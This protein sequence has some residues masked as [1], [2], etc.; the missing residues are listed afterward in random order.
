L[1]IESPVYDSIFSF[2]LPTAIPLL[3]FR[4]DIRKIINE[5]GHTLI[6]FVLGVIGVLL[7]VLTAHFLIPVGEFAAETAGLYTATYTGGSANFAA[8]TV[9]TEFQKGTELTAL[10]AADIIATNI[11][12]IVLIALPGILIIKQY[13]PA[14][15]NQAEKVEKKVDKN[16]PYI[17]KSLNLTGL[18]L[19]LTLAIFLVVLGKWMAMLSGSDA[20]AI[21][22]T[23]AFALIIA[24]LM[25]GVVKL[26]S[27]DYELGLFLVFLFLAAV[28][29]T[30]DAWTLLETGPIFFYYAMLLLFVH[31]VFVL[32]AGKILKIKL[33]DLI[34][35]STA[36]I[37]GTTTASAVASAK[38]WNHL[39]APGILIG[40]LGNAIGTFLGV[41]VWS[42][43]S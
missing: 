27:G 22:F 2:L 42:L 43:L 25:P 24:N 37:G 19:S 31:T 33:S 21:L 29:S 17:V 9:A 28:A 41:W 40:T 26:L 38:G 36:C 23:T 13:F 10:I 1:P 3:L 30:A 4:A 11:Q 5:A 12:L 18:A 39:I 20:M 32:V 15:F 7:G 16:L 8:V 35:G 14:E 34:I 6:A